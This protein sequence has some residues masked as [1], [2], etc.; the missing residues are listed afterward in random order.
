[1]QSFYC[2]ADITP[3][4]IFTN[5]YY[6]RE[7]SVDGESYQKIDDDFMNVVALDYLYDKDQ[8]YFVDV[9]SKKMFRMFMNTTEKEEII[10]HDLPMVEGL[11]LD[12]IG[13]LE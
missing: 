5:R 8:L 9:K 1:M 10:Q 3:W 2:F 13:R 4:L 12:W 11:T 6:I 7:I